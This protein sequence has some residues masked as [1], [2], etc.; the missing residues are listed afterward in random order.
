MKHLKREML[1]IMN[2]QL[3]KIQKYWKNIDNLIQLFSEMSWILFE[4]QTNW[5][6]N[7]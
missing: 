7:N 3:L 4:L 1:N 2:K 5:I 6:M